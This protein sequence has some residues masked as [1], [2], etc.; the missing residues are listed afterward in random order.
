MCGI[1]GFLGQKPCAEVLLN[2]LSRLEYRGYDS[3]GIAT[4]DRGR[5]QMRRAVGKVGEL[6][7]LLESEPLAG[8]LGIAHTRWATH[9]RPSET[10]AHPHLDASGRIALVHN[11]IVENHATLRSY[12]EKEGIE[13]SS[14]TDTESLV[15]LIGFFYRQSGDLLGSVRHALQEVSGTYGVAIMCADEPETLIAAR[16]GSPLSSASVMASSWWPRTAA[17]SWST[18]ARWST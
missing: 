18:P 5:L 13:F 11:G 16:R 17:P 3:A 2:G 10:N 12:L 8:S 4:L 9:G 7:R 15:Q 1:V 14:E 6:T